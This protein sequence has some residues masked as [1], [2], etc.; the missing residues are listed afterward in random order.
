MALMAQ[1]YK[2]DTESFIEKT[3]LFLYQLWVVTICYSRAD[4]DFIEKIILS[5]KIMLQTGDD[6]NSAGFI[7]ALPEGRGLK[8]TV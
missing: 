5:Q 6:W 7:L 3:V 1:T 4:W 8:Q 2:N